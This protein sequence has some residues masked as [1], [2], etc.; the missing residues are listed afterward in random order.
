MPDQDNAICTSGSKCHRTTPE[1][2][3]APS[4]H[5]Y[6]NR[7][8]RT[9]P[10]DLGMPVDFHGG[11]EHRPPKQTNHHLHQIR[12]LLA[13]PYG[14]CRCE[15]IVGIPSQ[16]V[17]I[18]IEPSPAFPIP[19]TFVF[20]ST[21]IAHGYQISWGARNLRLGEVSSKRLYLWGFWEAIIHCG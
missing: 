4:E 18:I 8:R 10:E 13:R 1:E 14:E 2:G 12:C 19:K 21:L 17:P 16:E 15:L 6:S 7:R 11:A 3:S 20:N 9:F 5:I